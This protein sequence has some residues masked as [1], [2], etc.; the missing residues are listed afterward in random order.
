[1]GACGGFVCTRNALTALN[2]LYMVV[3]VVVM[4]LGG[5]G[6][7]ASVVTSLPVVGGLVAAGLFLFLVAIL[8]LYG[9][10][11]HHQVVLFFYML[12]LFA[13]F[14]IQFFVAVA[15][16]AVSEEKVGVLVEQRWGE[17]GRSLQEEAMRR[18]G[19]C[20][21]GQLG[22]KAGEEELCFAVLPECKTSLSCQSCKDAIPPKAIKIVHVAGGVSLFFSFSEIL[23]IY[24]AM[25]FRN[26]KN[27]RANPNLFL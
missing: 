3:G 14:L 9:A 7:G 4:M 11:R 25:R 17:A 18:F 22:G 26:E 23:G 20:A 8:G 12:I 2:S 1:M 10:S 5:L 21:P 15:C 24:L 6:K 19:C 13:I 27:P 16:L